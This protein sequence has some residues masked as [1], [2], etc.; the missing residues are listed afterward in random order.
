MTER[1]VNPKP[2][3]RLHLDFDIVVSSYFRWL[4]A[5]YDSYCSLSDEERSR[6]RGIAEVGRCVFWC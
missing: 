1:T 5:V 6:L 3:S 4:R 2:E